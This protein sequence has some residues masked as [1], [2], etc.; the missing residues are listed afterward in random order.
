[1]HFDAALALEARMCARPSIARTQHRYAQ[2]LLSRARTDD[3]EKAA[4][5]LTSAEGIATDL[6]MKRLLEDV[7]DL[8]ARSRAVVRA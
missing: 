8:Q 7:V 3:R 4:Q 1:M 5:L 6:G 2:M